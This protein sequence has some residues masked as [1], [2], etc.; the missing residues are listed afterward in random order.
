MS[1]S[2]Y[3][4]TFAIALILL[5]FFYINFDPEVAT[6]FFIILVSG[7]LILIFDLFGPTGISFPIEKI[8][9]NR[10]KALIQVLGAY[11]IFV[12]ISILINIVLASQTNS[13]MSVFE[14]FSTNKPLLANNVLLTIFIWGF[15]IPFVETAVFFG[16]WM[17]FIKDSTKIR[18]SQ[19]FG[20][21][22]ILLALLMAG[23]FAFFH[24]Q[25]RFV[26]GGAVNNPALIITFVFGLL[27]S[28]MVLKYGEVKQAIALHVLVNTLAMFQKFGIGFALQG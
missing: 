22:N 20:V 18:T 26:Q 12:V 15:L 27:S 1:K 24:L 5:S 11:V 13:V 23:A 25:V 21:E 19:G 2:Q 10:K 9:S 28:L 3:F 14:I 16:I 6:T 17:E 4:V 7:I 8:S